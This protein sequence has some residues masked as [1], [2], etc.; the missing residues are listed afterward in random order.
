MFEIAIITAICLGSVLVSYAAFRRGASKSA[1]DYFVAGSSL[2]YFVLIF[3]L[4][5]SFLSAFAMFGISGM[6]FRLG[7]GTLFVLTVNLVP[8]GFL[9]YFLH[10]KT[11]LIG[12]ARRWM[13]MGAPFGERYGTPMRALIPIV[14]LAASIPYLVAQV[15]GIAV[16]TEVMT[17]GQIPYEAGLFFAPAFVVLYLILGGMKGAAWV[18][19]VQGTFFTVMVFILFF[20]VMNENGGFASTMKM[21]ED[22]HPHLFGLNLGSQGGKM[23][24]TMIFGLA[25]AMCLGAV[26]FPQPYMHA[27]SS[28]SAKG[29]KVMILAFGAICVVVISMT[30]MIGIAGW[31]LGPD[32]VGKATADLPGSADKIYGLAAAKTLPDWAAALAVAGA[33]TAAMTTVIGVVFGNASNLAND[34]YK[35]LKPQ[36]NPRELV[37]LGRYCIAGIM[38]VCV[39]IALNRDTP[40]AELAII[41]FGI[42]AV[43]I[44]PLWGAY[45][46]KRATGFGA[47]AAT[48]TGVGMNLAFL[49]WGVVA[50][51]IKGASDKILRP[52]DDLLGL[53]GFLV[54]FIVAGVVFFVGSLLTK[55]GRTENKSLGLFFHKTLD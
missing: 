2:G 1:D 4:L 28:K 7:F 26:C 39:L 30:T 12:R 19:T 40:V 33:F 15:R 22:K 27:Y 16:I 43:T 17:K 46:W 37:R 20:A 10:R 9:W 45:F 29:F 52:Q 5:A 38:A 11:L 48:L 53:N 31:S 55:L 24:L 14:V 44:F 8:L 54:S 25:A 13:S 35:L 42:M 3:S 50:G 23:S 34:L 6:G 41:A 18:N 36:A 21:V 47:I 32:V 51:G 49:V